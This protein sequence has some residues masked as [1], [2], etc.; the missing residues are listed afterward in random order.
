MI[1][2]FR[3]SDQLDRRYKRKENEEGKF[4]DQVGWLDGQVRVTY[5]RANAAIALSNNFLFLTEWTPSFQCH[6]HG[7]TMAGSSI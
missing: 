4:L 5:A 1:L 6:G 7:A 3:V 2:L